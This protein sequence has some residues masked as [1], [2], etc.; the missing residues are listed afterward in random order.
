MQK[1]KVILDAAKLRQC[2]QN[3]TY[4]NREGQEVQVQEVVV[5][6][7]ELN[8]DKQKVIYEH[9][10]FTNVKTHFAVKPQTQEE[11][12]AKADSVFVGDG[13]SQVWKNDTTQPQSVSEIKPI[14]EAD[15]DL[16]F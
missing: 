6:L 8:P 7:I 12:L 10:K 13:I 3:R 1:I 11:R 9:E 2:I 16:P 15:D 4:K 5:E 14:A